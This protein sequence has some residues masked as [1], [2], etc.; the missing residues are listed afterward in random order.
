MQTV[1]Q[2]RNLPLDLLLDLKRTA[3]ICLSD[4]DVRNFADEDYGIRR[5]NLL[6]WL[7]RLEVV[8]RVPRPWFERILF[9]EVA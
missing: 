9:D 7:S 4:L 1:E 2:I 3:L 5:L 8:L 6:T